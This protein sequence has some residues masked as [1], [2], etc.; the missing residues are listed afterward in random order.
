MASR[1]PGQGTSRPTWP[2][3]TNVSAGIGY[4]STKDFDQLAAMGIKLQRY[5]DTPSATL[6][7]VLEG[8]EKYQPYRFTHSDLVRYGWDIELTLNY[9]LLE[10]LYKL[11]DTQSIMELCLDPHRTRVDAHHSRQYTTLGPQGSGPHHATGADFSSMMG[12]TCGVIVTAH[13]KSPIHN[14]KRQGSEAAD[15]RAPEL[16]HWSD[17]TFLTYQ[18]L[19]KNI[20]PETSVEGLKHIFRFNIL[21]DITVPIIKAIVQRQGTF[22]SFL[23]FE[24]S[25]WS[26][27]L[28]FDASTEEGRAL[29][30]T[31]N[32]AGV[33]W[34][35]VRYREQLGWKRVKRV[36]IFGLGETSARRG[37]SLYFE[38]EDV[39]E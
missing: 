9:E 18:D 33:A 35:L 36:S 14:L 24:T 34:M 4:A 7:K 13:S 12:P 32:G 25:T 26:Q 39:K 3:P 28:S 22:A 1:Y 29:L 17:I 21:N 2:V 23:K 37:V 5:L 30:A 10:S 15:L 11:R 27:R 19:C 31:P 6:T 8:D 16:Q 38:L 20:R